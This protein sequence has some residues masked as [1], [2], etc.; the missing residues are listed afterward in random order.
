MAGILDYNQTENG[1]N[2]VNPNNTALSP[3]QSILMPWASPGTPGPAPLTPQQLALQQAQAGTPLPQG[4]NPAMLGSGGMAGMPRPQGFTGGMGAGM[5]SPTIGFGGLPSQPQASTGG[6][7]TAA[8]GAINTGLNMMQNSQ[9]ATQG[10]AMPSMLGGGG[11]IPQLSAQHTA[12]M[13]P[14]TG[15]MGGGMV[16]PQLLKMLMGAGNG[17]A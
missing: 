16:N 9:P 15:G 14:G 13:G 7:P 17:T 11:T 12:M 6:L 5:P 3:W 2:P 8:A 10:P 4:F 1:V